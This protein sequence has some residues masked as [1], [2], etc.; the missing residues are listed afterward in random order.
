MLTPDIIKEIEAYGM[1]FRAFAF[2]WMRTHDALP[3][4]NIEFVQDW[5]PIQW[6]TYFREHGIE[7]PSEASAL[8]HTQVGAGR[9]EFRVKMLK[10]DHRPRFE[11]WLR[12]YLP[13][14]SE[15]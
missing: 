12:K 13:Y 7:K 6:D 10:A 11:N 9:T 4:T 2:D 15:D 8:A 3:E 5:M 14:P 1:P